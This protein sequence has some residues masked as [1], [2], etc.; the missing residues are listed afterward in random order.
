MQY[1][2]NMHNHVMYVYVHW[3]AMVKTL[4]R[5]VCVSCLSCRKQLS[6]SPSRRPLAL[7]SFSTGQWMPHMTPCMHQS[8]S[9]APV[10]EACELGSDLHTQ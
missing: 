5:L 10:R 3:C 6:S 9:W 4:L 2:M 8:H 7:P 1:D